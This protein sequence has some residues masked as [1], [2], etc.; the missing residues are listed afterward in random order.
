MK[1]DDDG[2]MTVMAQRY[3]G[4]IILTIIGSHLYPLSAF[5]SM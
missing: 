1:H 2:M 5:I 4:T 3:N